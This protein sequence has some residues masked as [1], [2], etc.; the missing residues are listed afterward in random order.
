MLVVPARSVFVIE[1]DRN[2]IN[3]DGV[4]FDQIRLGQCGGEN[5]DFV[6]TACFCSAHSPRE[7][8][9]NNR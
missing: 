4:R 3:P 9:Q 2:E 5:A 7:C 6:H 1:I 8:N